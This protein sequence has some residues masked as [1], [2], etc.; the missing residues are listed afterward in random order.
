MHLGT[1]PAGVIADYQAREK[2]RELGFTAV[3]DPLRA[4]QLLAGELVA[5]KDW[6]RGEVERL[7][8]IR[9]TDDKG[10]EQL[11]GELTAYQAALRDTMTALATIARL[12]IDERLA[13]IN[14]RQAEAVLR[15]IDAALDA[16]GVPATERAEPKKAAARH[17]RVA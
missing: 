8:A 3:E 13:R 12:N 14:E 4:L 2:V 1:K 9:Y 15:A 10:A 5:V 11:R 6:L 16:A 17:L 7:R